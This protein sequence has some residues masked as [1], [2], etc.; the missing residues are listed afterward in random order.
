MTATLWDGGNKGFSFELALIHN[1]A[2]NT[3][4]YMNYFDNVYG[5]SIKY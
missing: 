3:Q 2:A 4:L 5:R 1:L